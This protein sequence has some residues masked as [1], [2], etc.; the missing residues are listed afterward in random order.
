MTQVNY[1]TIVKTGQINGQTAYIY[2]QPPSQTGGKP[3][4]TLAIDNDGVEGISQADNAIKFA[5]TGNDASGLSDLKIFDQTCIG[6]TSKTLGQALGTAPFNTID[7]QMG[8]QNLQWYINPETKRST[9]GAATKNAE[10]QAIYQAQ[11]YDYN[12]D[13]KTSQVEGH[14][15]KMADQSVAITLPQSNKQ[16]AQQDVSRLFSDYRLT[17]HKAATVFS[18]WNWQHQ[19]A[20]Y[21]LPIFD[22]RPEKSI[23]TAV[24]LSSP[25]EDASEPAPKQTL[26]DKPLSDIPTTTI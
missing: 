21:Q 25:S 26:D 3:V 24:T 13:N 1:G 6:D 8:D 14:G 2:K 11:C 5:Y 7:I 23:S 20:E 22:S 10:G 15:I 18:A 4:L 17:T 19:T 9:L 16:Q 12:Y